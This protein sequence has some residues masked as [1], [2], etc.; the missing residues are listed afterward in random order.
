MLKINTINNIK[1]GILTADINN[2]IVRVIAIMLKIN[3]VAFSIFLALFS[4]RV[5][6]KNNRIEMLTPHTAQI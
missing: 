6:A 1:C 3:V 5:L 2:I 4:I